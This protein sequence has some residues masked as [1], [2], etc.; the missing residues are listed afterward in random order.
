MS[1]EFSKTVSHTNTFE[2]EHGFTVGVEVS[3]AAKIPFV[4]K[5]EVTVSGE[6]SHNW[7]YGTEN[8]EEST[9]SASTP[10]V[11]PAGHVYQ[12]IA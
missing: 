6:T 11:V 10:L 9:F 2:H 12:A 8:T 7:K 3:V 4:G 5:S 1:F